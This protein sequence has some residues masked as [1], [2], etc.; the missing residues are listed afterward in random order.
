MKKSSTISGTGVDLNLNYLKE[1]S[2]GSAEFMVEMLDIF[3]SQTPIYLQELESALNEKNYVVVAE[4]A[5]KI[6][7]TFTFIGFDHAT[8]VMAQLEQL[9]RSEQDFDLIVTAYQELKPQLESVFVRL[10]EVKKE[11]GA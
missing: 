7:P 9:A 6:R 8:E 11:L 4:I 10:T 2:D 3:M 1:I 5:H